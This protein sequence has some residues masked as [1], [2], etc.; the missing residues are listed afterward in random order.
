M[1]TNTPEELRTT[2]KQDGFVA[3]PGFLNEAEV[4]EL[5]REL[6][7]FIQ[8]KV[9]NLSNE[10]TFYDDRDDPASLK[11]IQKLFEYDEYFH[12]MMFDSR[13]ERLA[14]QLL[15]ESVRGANLQYFNKP[16]GTNLAT[17]P[18]QDGF[19][20]MLEPN[21]AVT[22][23]L[24]VDATD[25]ENGCV[26]YIPGSHLAGLRR[27]QSTG[28][29]GFS[30]GLAEFTSNDVQNEVAIS[31]SPGT[32]LVHHAL[33]IHRADANRSNSR[34]RRALGFIYYSNATVES[35]EKERRQQQLL[36]ELSKRGK[37]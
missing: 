25:E 28:T 29:L 16:P 17:P 14:E 21:E 31:A 32:L 18:H 27:H 13:C 23:W 30:Q 3:I 1:N 15:G 5:E 7:R 6:T 10:I 22:M 19:Y 24:A 36:Q 4:S 37:I 20:F 12:R 8:R 9:P 2:F 35:P 33:T 34:Q 26:R 11:Q